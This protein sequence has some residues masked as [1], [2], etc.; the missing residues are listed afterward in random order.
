MSTRSLDSTSNS[1]ERLF[2]CEGNYEY[3]SFLLMSFKTVLLLAKYKAL[4][5]LTIMLGFNDKQ[6]VFHF[7]IHQSN[8]VKEATDII[9]DIISEEEFKL[10]VLHRGK[11]ELFLFLHEEGSLFDL[12]TASSF[13]CFNF[14]TEE[15]LLRV[16]HAG[17]DQYYSCYFREALMHSVSCGS[18]LV[19]KI[20]FLCESQIQLLYPKNEC[21][22]YEN[23]SLSEKLSYSFRSYPS[24][25]AYIFA[26]KALTYSDLGKAASYHAELLHNKIKKGDHVFILIDNS[27]EL[28]LAYHICI[29]LGAIFTPLDPN[30]PKERID[31]LISFVNPAALFVDGNGYNNGLIYDYFHYLIDAQQEISF[32][33]DF[34]IPLKGTDPLYGFFTSGSTGIPKHTINRHDGI[35]NRF[36]YMSKVLPIKAESSTIL[37]NS[38]ITFDS[39]LWQL[40]W[41]LL[42]GCKVV[43]PER[44]KHLDLNY[45]ISL[46]ERHKIT[47]TDFVPSVFNLLVEK[48]RDSNLI[49]KLKSLRYLIV[50][51]EESSTFYISEFY[52]LFSDVQLINTYGHT[53]ASIGMVFYNID[54]NVDYR[55]IPLG[56][57]ID[58]TFVVVADSNHN[59]LPVGAIGEIFVGGIC[60][61]EGYFKD[62]EKNKATF[63]LNPF[64][65]INSKRIFRTGDYGYWGPDHKLYYKGRRDEQ[66]KI[67]GVRLDLKEIEL[68]I[69]DFGNIN[70]VK[71]LFDRSSQTIHAFIK[72]DSNYD[73]GLLKSF[74]ANRIP[75]YAIPSSFNLI[76]EYPLNDNGKIDGKA[77]LELYF[78]R[79]L[80][81]SVLV[82]QDSLTKLWCKVLKTNYIDPDKTFFENGGG[83]LKAISMI[84][85]V[86]RMFNIPIPLEEVYNDLKIGTILKILDNKTL[87]V[88]TSISHKQLLDDYH[89]LISPEH[90]FLDDVL[91]HGQTIFLSGASGFIGSN[92]LSDL[93][94]NEAIKKVI[95]LVR[96]DTVEQGYTKV[97]NA[98]KSKENTNL[99]GAFEKIVILLGDLCKQGFGLSEEVFYDLAKSVDILIHNGAEVDFI[100]NY[101]HV[102]SANTLSIEYFLKLMTFGRPKSLHFLSS[103]SVFSDDYVSQHRFI[104][105]ENSIDMD[106]VPQGGYNQSK[107]ITEAVIGHYVDKGLRAHIYRL[108]EAGPHSVEG[109]YN[110]KS[111][112]VKYL[113]SVIHCGQA[114]DSELL[115]DCTP[116]D[117]ITGR[118]VSALFERDQHTYNLVNPYGFT[119]N[120]LTDYISLHF[121]SIEKVPM[122]TFKQRLKR[123]INIGDREYLSTIYIMLENS[124][125]PLEELFYSHVSSVLSKSFASRRDKFWW[126]DNLAA[127]LKITSSVQVN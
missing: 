89:R 51:G 82:E 110:D 83:S 12:K 4:E 62:E 30:W 41:P 42:H 6:G 117:Y 107:W 104:P 52:K 53:E 2:V 114:P 35:I 27:L 66:I 14:G 16:E 29:K 24:N 71:V 28:P 54:R 50:G 36:D 115:L 102:R 58:N 69:I 120:E 122:D 38:N 77:L 75:V 81:Q 7:D 126:L 123:E 64:E 127:F 63:Y 125:A 86:E 92:L 119:I 113:K 116:I 100:K 48:V 57:P 1:H 49:E 31:A 95:C 19:K 55:E 106:V 73:T 5:K 11:I 91:D 76:T 20:N 85:E 13:L 32:H 21:V 84:L 25:I 9:K 22:S 105:E 68:N 118:I 56:K 79:Q 78:S 44:K 96:A 23:C 101:Q 60:I 39:S 72:S 98:L 3:E 65:F 17:I 40:L 59:P 43:I 111:M 80:D 97:V 108:G 109:W 74:L 121:R 103:I 70:S 45:T 15:I 87:N 93:I 26:D 37:Q 47:M 67:G 112:F 10:S 90:N 34:A 124:Q 33:P 8:F 99:D 94:R 46:I 88:N 18:D 61:G